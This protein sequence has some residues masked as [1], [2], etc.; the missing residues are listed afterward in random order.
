MGTILIDCPHKSDFFNYYVYMIHIFGFINIVYMKKVIFVIFL[1]L[2]FVCFC[3]C[4]DKKLSELAFQWSSKTIFFPYNMCFTTQAFDTI[5]FDYQ[6]NLRVLYYVDSTGCSSCKLNLSVWKQLIDTVSMYSNNRCS[7]IIS[8]TPKNKNYVYNEL[9]TKFSISSF[10]YPVCIDF[11]DSLNILNHFPSDERFHCFLLDENNRV[12]LIGNPVQNPKIKELYIRTICERLG[13]DYNL[14]QTQEKSPEVNLGTF[15]KSETKS[16]TFPIRNSEQSEMVI[17]TLF[18]SCEC[19]TAQINK[20]V[21]KPNETATLSVTYTPDGG[22]DFYRE[23]YVKL[24]NE[25]IPLV[26]KIRGNVE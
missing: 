8:F 6:N 7:F 21:I 15:S 14:Q 24:K 9:R 20:N 13:I 25:E 26:F 18:T 10:D 22:G 4:D 12:I 16:A 2:M 3:M 11:E 23:V 1:H 17:D 5:D 19:T